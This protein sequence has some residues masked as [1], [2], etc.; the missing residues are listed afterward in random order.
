MATQSDILTALLAA[1]PDTYDKSVGSFIWDNLNAVAGDISQID[2]SITTATD[3]LDMANLTY[4]ELD[5]RI[6]DR[7]GLT[8]DAAT[9][10]TGTVTLTGTGTVNAGDVVET[11]AGTQFEITA[12]TAITTSGD[13][14]I[15]ALVAGS[16]GNVAAGTITLFP[17]TLT[18]FTAVTNTA[19]TTGGADQESDA[20]YLQRYYDYVQNPL[21]SGN[22]N[23]YVVWAKSIPGI[24]GTVVIPLWNGP[25]TVKV[26]VIGSDGLPASSS[27]VAAVQNYLDPG[28]TGQGNGIA[29]IGAFV[30]VESASPITI[31]ISATLVLAPGYTLDVVTTNIQNSLT[32]LFQ[33]VAFQQTP[34]VSYAKVGDVL[35]NSIGV[36]DYSNLTINGSA[37]NVSVGA[38][39]VPVLG[40]TSFTT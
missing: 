7:T 37:T 26:V 35:I 1:I 5:T 36:D 4:P 6:Y 3:M 25:N 21:T 12:T 13:V 17:Q 38:E 40:T 8:R 9:Y 31:N 23:E 28:T 19:P 29:P 20:S 15:Q 27:I 34:I 22:K 2:I 32:S 39:Q 16:A 18:G 33:T 10:A 24:G 14:P 30:T 11:A